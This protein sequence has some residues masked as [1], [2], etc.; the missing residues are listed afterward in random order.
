MLVL[1]SWSWLAVY[2]RVYLGSYIAVSNDPTPYTLQF[3]NTQQTHKHGAGLLM[4]PQLSSNSSSLELQLLLILIRSKV[5][6]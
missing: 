2:Y 1:V 3:S 6:M 5:L 4:V